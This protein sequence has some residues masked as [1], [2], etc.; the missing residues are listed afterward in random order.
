MWGGEAAGGILPLS[1]D[2]G[3]KAEQMYRVALRGTSGKG[4][5]SLKD[6]VFTVELAYRD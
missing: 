2:E 4:R 6:A 5:Y 3:W 1:W